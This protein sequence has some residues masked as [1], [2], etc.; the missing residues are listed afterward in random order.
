[1]STQ[2]AREIVQRRAPERIEH[3]IRL[4]TKFEGEGPLVGEIRA[5]LAAELGRPYTDDEW[6]A[7]YDELGTLI[8]NRPR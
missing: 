3:F 2:Q 8:L 5:I 7:A 1:M 6:S 4:G